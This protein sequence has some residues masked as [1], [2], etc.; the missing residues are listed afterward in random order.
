MSKLNPLVPKRLLE[1]RSHKRF[2]SGRRHVSSTSEAWELSSL[3]HKLSNIHDHLT[4][5]LELC[6]RHIGQSEY[7]FML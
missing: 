1:A 5:Q 7:K 3:A 6:Y 2:F 4:K